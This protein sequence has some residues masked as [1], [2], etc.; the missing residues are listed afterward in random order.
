MISLPSVYVKENKIK[1]GD[2]LELNIKDSQLIIGS[3]YKPEKSSTRIDVSNQKF[4]LNKITAATYKAGYD[5]ILIHFSKLEE[6]KKVQYVIE[7]NL[8]GFDIIEFKKDRVKVAT[9]ST[10]H[11]EKFDTILHKCFFTFMDISNDTLNALKKSNFDELKLIV[12]RDKYVDK[13]TDFCRRQLNRNIGTKYKRPLPLYYILEEI[14]IIADMYRDICNYVSENKIKVSSVT[15]NFMKK[16]NE[17][18]KLY[19]ETFFKFNL[20]NIKEIGERRES[21]NK[22]VDEL[23]PK[24]SKKDLKVF[25]LIVQIFNATYETK[26]ALLT[27]FL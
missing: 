3:E 16:V 7:R 13:Y 25:M 21:I 20:D 24:I 4:M 26:S 14:E 8:T 12:I 11:S 10:L 9:I 22:L 19:T 2:E 27:L 1:K 23:I 18:F 5:E 17:F 6:I 15:L